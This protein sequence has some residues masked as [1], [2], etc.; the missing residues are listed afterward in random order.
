MDTIDEEVR[1]LMSPRVLEV[2]ACILR[3][4]NGEEVGLLMSP[5]VLEVPA[6]IFRINNSILRGFKDCYFQAVDF[7]FKCKAEG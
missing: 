3:I 1:L 2:S 4:G 5:R 7:F 6:C